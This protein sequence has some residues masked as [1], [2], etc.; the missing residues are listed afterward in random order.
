MVFIVLIEFIFNRL[1][2]SNSFQ[3]FPILFNSFE[4]L[5]QFFSILFYF[6]HNSFQFFLIS[7]AILFNSFQFFRISSTILFN[8]FQFFLISSTIP[9][10]SFQFFLISSTIL[11]NSFYFLLQFFSILSIFFYSSFQFFSILSHFFYSSVQFFLIFLNLSWLDFQ[12]ALTLAMLII[13]FMFFQVCNF[14]WGS[15][16]L[17]KSK[18]SC[19]FLWNGCLL[20]FLPSLLSTLLSPFNISVSLL[21]PTTSYSWHFLH[22]PLLTQSCFWLLSSAS[23][24]RFSSLRF[25]CPVGMV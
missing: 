18:W 11:F 12:F 9:F 25:E 6:F 13:I 1:N 4:F 16:A 2:L 22:M 17:L 19:Q 10:N 24:L 23:S 15:F 3:F 7:S 20:P 14:S 21:F 5:L 8:S